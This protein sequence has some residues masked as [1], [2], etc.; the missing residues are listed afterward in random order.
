M[1][2]KMS[3]GRPY[4]NLLRLVTI[5]VCLVLLSL[6]TAYAAA[7]RLLLAY[8]TDSVVL[9]DKPHALSA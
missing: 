8:R 3:V 4:L 7:P 5:G 9:D 6:G 2:K 1:F